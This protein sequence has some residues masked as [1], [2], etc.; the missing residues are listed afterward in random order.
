MEWTLLSSRQNPTV[1]RVLSLRD[2]KARDEAGLFAVEGTR[3]VSDLARDGIFPAALFLREGARLSAKEAE[4]DFA[5]PKTKL[6]ALTAPVYEKLSEESAG[7][8]VFAVYA[9]SDLPKTDRADRVLALEDLRDPGNVGTCLRTAAALGFDAVWLS[10]CADPLGPKALRASMGAALRIP[11]LMLRD[12][13]EMLSLAREKGL[14]TV[15]ACL[16]DDA[17]DLRSL[18]VKKPLCLFIGNEGHGLSEAVCKG[19]DL[20]VVIPMRAMESL[21]AAS[22]ASIL[23]WEVTR[24]EA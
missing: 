8:G 1:K 11:F 13:G 4:A 9:A 15:A 14:F 17:A 20:R 19:A 18:S 6:F 23:M 12:G 24:C 5:G 2:K 3:F 16:A 10:G 7:E 22:A 21:N